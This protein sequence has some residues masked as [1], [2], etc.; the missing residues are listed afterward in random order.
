MTPPPDPS[1]PPGLPPL[2]AL[3]RETY[4][5]Q[6]RL[7]GF[8]EQAQRALK[9]ASVL[10]SRVGGLGSPVAMELA[11]AGVGRLV[12][13][14]AGNLKQSDLNRQLLMTQEWVGRPRVA[15][16]AR[17]LREFQPRLEVVACD[18]NL[19]PAN[20]ARLVG[21]VDVV[22][23]CAPLFEERFAM[24]DEAFRQ[25]KPVVECAMYGSEA[26]ITTVVPGRTA[27]LRCRVPEVPPHWR[28]EFPVLGAVSGAVGCLAAM[29]AIKLLTGLGSGLLDRLLS[30]D[31]ASMN[32]NETTLARR[33]GCPVCGTS[34]G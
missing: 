19:S 8:G 22:V 14:H 30:F 10:V 34:C 7:P 9:G 23:D 33:Q 15:C 29:E 32:W 12:L 5:W 26:S 4:A 11:A 24:H 20:A 13:A 2:D 3:D 28:R 27:C 17:R 31:L 6:L 16:A 25:H 1:N 21:E 18:E